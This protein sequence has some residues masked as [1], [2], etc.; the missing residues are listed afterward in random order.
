[1]LFNFNMTCPCPV[2]KDVPPAFSLGKDH[3]VGSQYSTISFFP[4]GGYSLVQALNQSPISALRDTICSDAPCPLA[5]PSPSR[6]HSKAT[7]RSNRNPCSASLY[8]LSASCDH[9]EGAPLLCGLPGG[10]DS[11]RPTDI[12]NVI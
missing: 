4:K 5:S 7:K 9:L 3:P 10:I 11:R 2:V 1:M 6:C 12:V 8:I